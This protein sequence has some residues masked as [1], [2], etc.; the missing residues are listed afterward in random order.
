MK[1][2]T[3]VIDT[4]YVDNNSHNVISMKSV[5][6]STINDKIIAQELQKHHYDIKD[7]TSGN[8]DI[9]DIITNG[10]E[11]EINKHVNKRDCNE[12]TNEV[13]KTQLKLP[14]IVN[15][16][17]NHDVNKN[18]KLDALQRQIDTLI[19][20]QSNS[21]SNVTID[22]TLMEMEKKSKES[23]NKKWL[24]FWN[25]IVFVSLTFSIA[26]NIHY[27]AFRTPCVCF[28]ESNIIAC[29]I[30]ALNLGSKSPTVITDD[31]N[32]FPTKIPT[33][34]PTE[35]PSQT[36]IMKPSYNPTE[37]PTKTPT[38]A[39]SIEPTGK[40]STT[41]AKTPSM[42][43]TEFPTKKPTTNPSYQVSSQSVLPIGSIILWDNCNKVP[44]GISPIYSWFDWTIILN[45]I[46]WQ[47]CDGTGLCPDLRGRF[48]VGGGT[49]Y[50]YGTTGGS[51][52]HNHGIL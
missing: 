48:I 20:I 25:L 28:D 3:V 4:G 52:T 36:P 29:E 10:S 42:D 1:R 34:I 44:N 40:P 5:N 26:G 30:G 33:M 2:E 21:G 37:T 22:N 17:N 38:V 8:I 7:I 6:N 24:R 31:L 32:M 13:K 39:P 35:I 19:Q 51:A 49:S 16:N 41:P 50:S 23:R 12:D 18:D 11:M 45:Q 46:G 27:I 15:M 43:P 47:I 14:N 9:H